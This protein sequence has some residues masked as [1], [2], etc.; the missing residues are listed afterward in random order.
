MKLCLCFHCLCESY[1]D[2][3]LNGR[4]LFVSKADFQ[5]LIDQLSERG[6]RFSS[7]EDPGP[8]TVSV[9]FDDGY[10]NNFLFEDLAQKNA[11]PYT[12]FVSAYYVESGAEFPWFANDGDDYGSIQNFDF[13]DRPAGFN[14][15]QV[16]Q[17]SDP[18]TRPM[19]IDELNTLCRGGLAEIGCHGYFHQALSKR[20]AG[21]LHRERDLSMP[22]LQ[23]SL[24]VKPKYYAL[25]NGL[26]TKWVL[27]ELLKS[28]ERVFTIEGRPFRT[29]EPV[30]HRLTILNPNIG[31]PLIQQIDRQLQSL[32]Q[33]RR[34]VR[35]TTR[36]FLWP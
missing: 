34:A 6:Y 14:S 18:S 30:V 12:V 16:S 8:N 5:T 26:Y 35:T 32:R 24:G 20:F 4:E 23:E 29:G 3:P 27:R 1:E 13:Y 21:H 19:T 36:R 22:I 10:F 7:M 15:P 33:V 2:T 31:G 25:A 9:S 11:I 28:F 17:A